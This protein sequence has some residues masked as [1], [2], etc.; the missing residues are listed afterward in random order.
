MQRKTR[1]VSFVILGLIAV[2]A[3]PGRQSR[4]RISPTGEI[5]NPSNPALAAV[6]FDPLSAFGTVVRA[7]YCDWG[8][9]SFGDVHGNS[10]GWHAGSYNKCS[11]EVRI[12]KGPGCEDQ[13]IY[14]EYRGDFQCGYGSQAH[15]YYPLP[16]FDCGGP[17]CSLRCGDYNDPNC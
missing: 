12:Y 1:L 17:G 4:S 10:S 11:N 2:V 16:T 13:G 5:R 8:E 7:N 3:A 15:L 6:P 9:F 14:Y